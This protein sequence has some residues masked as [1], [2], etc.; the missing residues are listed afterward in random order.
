M[1][2]ERYAVWLNSVPPGREET[3]YRVVRKNNRSKSDP[4]VHSLLSGVKGGAPLLVRAFEEAE[5]AENLAKEF[6]LHGAE[7]EVR[8]A[9]SVSGAS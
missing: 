5:S 9:D 7:V 3:M 8:E 2:N 1:S 6:R 4:E